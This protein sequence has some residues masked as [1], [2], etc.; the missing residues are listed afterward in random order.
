MSE[1][2]G[3]ITVKLNGE[4][5]K[6][7]PSFHA[8]M[9]IEEAARLSISELYELACVGKLSAR[10]LGAIY[11]GGIQGHLSYVNSRDQDS[12]ENSFAV[13]GQKVMNDGIGVHGVNAMRFLALCLTPAD[14]MADLNEKF[15]ESQKKS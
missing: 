15:D 3:E 9:E 7:R 12:A 5:V 6:M 2:K 1:W 8:M 10:A 13:V 14:Q 4:D 11:Y